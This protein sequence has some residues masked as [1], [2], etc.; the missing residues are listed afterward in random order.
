MVKSHSATHLD[1]WLDDCGKSDMPDLVTFASGIKADYEA[2]KAA[3][4]TRWSNARTE[5][6]VNRIKM[7]KRQMFGRANFDLLRKRILY[8]G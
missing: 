1:S 4:T 8:Y 2:V 7:I 5:G 6:H 3:L